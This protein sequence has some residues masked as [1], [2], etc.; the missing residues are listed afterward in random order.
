MSLYYEELRRKHA[1]QAK[2]D[3]CEESFRTKKSDSEYDF[4]VPKFVKAPSRVRTEVEQEAT[5][6]REEAK[7]RQTKSDKILVGRESPKKGMLKR[8]NR[9]F[10]MKIR[11][12]SG[13]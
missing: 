2:S 4:L 9:R 3:I 11:K 6:V 13:F 8:D 12:E 5:K 7:R 10:T 1:L